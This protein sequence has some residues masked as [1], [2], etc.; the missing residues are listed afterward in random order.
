MRLLTTMTDPAKTSMPL[1]I[2]LY[3]VIGHAAGPLMRRLARHRLNAG[4]E[5]GARLDE[6]WGITAAAPTSSAPLVWVHAASVGELNACNGLIHRLLDRALNV[7]LTTGTVTSAH[8]A[9]KRYTNPVVHQY[10]PYDCAP[11]VERFLDHWRPELAIFAESELWPTTI[12][13]LHGRGIPVCLVNAHISQSSLT[14]WFWARR[15]A[16]GILQRFSVIAAQSQTAAERLQRLGACNVVVSGNLKFDTKPLTYDPADLRRLE[17]T[18]GRR[19]L[20][21]AASTHA[22]EEKMVIDVHCSMQREHP[23]LVT[24]VAP[25]HPERRQEVKR[26][27]INKGLKVALRST[28]KTPG[29]NTQVFLIDTIGELGVFYR[30]A[31]LA[32]VGGSLVPHGGQNPIEP[33]ILDCAIIHGPHTHN[34]ADIYRL[35]TKAN[36]SHRVDDQSQLADAVRHYLAR[37]ED[38]IKMARRAALLVAQNRGAL[39]KTMTALVPLLAPLTGATDRRHRHSRKP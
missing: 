27:C 39:D 25:R 23:N 33:T 16:R 6:R 18:I 28:D 29:P 37:P 34:L 17:K 24:L 38:A 14:R 19:P 3:R 31:A 30:L 7:I 21:L 35:F 32:F 10:A 1:P 4:K 9:A 22:G 36:G 2:R 12:S 5:D 13:S 8:L 26:L 11:Y 20:W 15:S